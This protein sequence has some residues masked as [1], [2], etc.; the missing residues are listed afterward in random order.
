MMLG[1]ELFE[2]LHVG[3]SDGMV[4]VVTGTGLVDPAIHAVGL[5]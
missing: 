2:T 4:M 1:F 5:M 3:V